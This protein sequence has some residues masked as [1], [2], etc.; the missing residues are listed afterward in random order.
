MSWV[1]NFLKGMDD[2]NT[3]EAEEWN[4]REM[5]MGKRTGTSAKEHTDWMD[6][7]RE[8][9]N[10][11]TTFLGGRFGW[12]TDVGD[13][14][15]PNMLKKA[16]AYDHDYMNLDPA[17]VQNAAAITAKLYGEKVRER[18]LGRTFVDAMQRTGDSLV[19]KGL[20]LGA[21]L[22]V[23]GADWMYEGS[24]A[25]GEDAAITT[26]PRG[27]ASVRDVRSFKDGLVWAM[28]EAGE[29]APIAALSY[30]AGAVGGAVGKAGKAG[31][32]A[33][34][35]ANKGR[36]AGV[37][38]FFGAYNT[39]DAVERRMAEGREI[40]WEG[41]AVEAAGRTGVDMALGVVAR[42]L[43]RTGASR[44]MGPELLRG[45]GVEEVSDVLKNKGYYHAM[46]YLKRNYAATWGAY[47]TTV[48]KDGLLM[49]AAQTSKDIVSRT[50]RMGEGNGFLKDGEA[51]SDV[52]AQWFDAGVSGFALGAAHSAVSNLGTAR[53]QIDGAK[54]ARAQAEMMFKE[55]DAT[56]GKGVNI[57]P[58]DVKIM[59]DLI[60]LNQQIIGAEAMLKQQ[61]ADLR[62]SK[63]DPRHVAEAMRDLAKKEAKVAEAQR[64]IDAMQWVLDPPAKEV[65]DKIMSRYSVR[66]TTDV[67][68]DFRG[69]VDV[70]RLKGSNPDDKVTTVGG[71][72]VRVYKDSGITLA[73]D[74]K[75]GE[76]VLRN[77]PGVAYP[78]DFQESYSPS[79]FDGNWDNALKAAIQGAERLS[80]FNDYNEREMDKA[81]A[82]TRQVAASAGVDVVCVR[83]PQAEGVPDDVR[84]ELN[85]SFAFFNP[86]DGK[87]YV[88]VRKMDNPAIVNTMVLH[89]DFHGKI[90]ALLKTPE[91]KALYENF[92]GTLPEDEKE[93]V[94]E[95]F[96]SVYAAG[97]S[98][99]DLWGMFKAGV[100]TWLHEDHGLSEEL[101]EGLKDDTVRGLIAMILGRQPTAADAREFQ[102]AP[103]A[104]A[105]TQNDTPPPA[106][107]EVAAAP[108]VFGGVE[109]PE[110]L[111]SML[112]DYVERENDSGRKISKRTAEREFAKD[113]R[114]L[115]MEEVVEKYNLQGDEERLAREMYGKMFPAVRVNTRNEDAMV[116]VEMGVNRP[117]DG[118]IAEPNDE[119]KAQAI[120]SRP[121]VE[122]PADT[123]IVA[124]ASNVTPIKMEFQEAGTTW[125]ATTPE[126]AHN[127]G[128]KYRVVSLDDGS[129]RTSDEGGYNRA[130]QNRNDNTLE[131]RALAINN[132]PGGIDP[133]SLEQN[134]ITSD[135]APIVEAP[136]AQ[137]KSDT[138]VG[139]AR[140]KALRN[141]YANPAKKEEADRYSNHVLE[142]ATRR[143]I[144][145]PENAGA[146]NIALVREL[147]MGGMTEAQRIDFVKKSN[148]PTVTPLKAVENAPNDAQVILSAG[149]LNR[150]SMD[151]ESGLA[152]AESQDFMI[153]LSRALHDPSILQDD[154]VSASKNG[155][156]RAKAA[157]LTLAL[158]EMTPEGN[159][160]VSDDLMKLVG[161]A[162]EN[163]HE[164]G[165]KKVMDAV[166]NA[167]PALV[168]VRREAPQHNV[169]G[170]LRRVLN[171]YIEAFKSAR[172]EGV[173]FEDKILQTDLFDD[174]AGLESDILLAI[175]RNRQSSKKLADL[176]KGFADVARME[177]GDQTGMLGI[178]EARGKN[179]LWR[180]VVNLANERD[181]ALPAGKKVEAAP[182][183][184]TQPPAAEPFA[185]ESAGGEEL[186][187]EAKRRAEREA[188][189]KQ[190]AKPITD[191]RTAAEFDNAQLDLGGDNR[192]TNL[193]EAANVQKAGRKN[194][195]DTENARLEELKAKMR[196]M[197]GNTNAGIRKMSIKGADGGDINREV[198][199]V[200]VEMTNLYV[201]SG[202][203]TFKDFGQIIHDELGDVWDNIKGDLLGL[204]AASGARNRHIDEV[205]RAQADKIIA[206]ID[207]AKNAPINKEAAKPKPPDDSTTPTS[208]RPSIAR[209]TMACVSW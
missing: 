173:R 202:I 141:L 196:A 93:A 125:A 120:P 21:G 169:S 127:V 195:T 12:D 154:G 155:I 140:I 122:K 139:N 167:A 80:A 153:G 188:M 22:G 185:L 52:G 114:V 201:K 19:N 137:G 159:L 128:G 205:T 203:R 37:V 20:A 99:P 182:P 136:D 135:G 150:L 171:Q 174:K 124:D 193:F 131:A 147:D 157:L 23:P 198:F 65:F 29:Y 199:E 87:T 42:N 156:E 83:N 43:R 67:P 27:V 36:Q 184:V 13:G 180:D 126:R 170:E 78:K 61:G 96:A 94:D 15:T 149:L 208:C 64:H 103:A 162:I 81:E 79:D 26:R 17:W 119:P 146:G 123:G 178:V 133:L 8:T 55:L 100:V 102:A 25:L 84:R 44:W 51:W 69:R 76:V 163:S 175:Y 197:L 134:R 86:R 204:W 38:G 168:N 47:G 98:K 56:L 88:D 35:A 190:Q 66:G 148:D 187:T 60:V 161:L 115:P 109:I 11:Q 206:G 95:F 39:A 28:E 59:T 32:A 191:K 186:K 207:G 54:K 106:P 181:G 111:D 58:V 4:T 117:V 104:P 77:S 1:E 48:L 209:M 90:A 176:F 63:A 2:G 194:L 164:E 158:G 41:V 5:L 9:A 57:H 189:A 91:G 110:G 46:M 144:E 24:K 89:E 143:G 166:M 72:N 82:Y 71:K 138:I 132:K 118:R 53:T 85:N 151:E 40:N 74:V 68:P 113:V 34:Q 116:E 70:A 145:M 160:K 49:G 33:I 129:V 165:V 14:V 107:T 73:Q 105:E 31:S 75:S 172:R 45:K 3:H 183:P 97:F 6:R 30:G 177:A 50:V 112:R 152:S 142:F 62:T 200:G 92:L 130:N 7:T 108:A 18:G 10:K 179:E 192:P 101:L 16:W 121:V